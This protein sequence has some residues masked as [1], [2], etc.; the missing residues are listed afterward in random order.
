[1]NHRLLTRILVVVL[2]SSLV[3]GC[4]WI[5]DFVILNTSSGDLAI[6]YVVNGKMC[7]DD[8]F[9]SIPAT[10]TISEL[11]KEQGAWRKLTLSQYTCDPKT[12][13]VTTT[14]PPHSAL[15][16]ARK[17][18]YTGPE[19]YGNVDFDVLRLELKG[20]EGAVSLTGLKV[21]KSFKRQ[22]DVLYVFS[23]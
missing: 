3:A 19:N 14:L 6:T 15:R 11:K 22:S 18:T 23:Y 10:K 2:A 13:A 17:G 1:M 16:V 4:S 21:L 20:T 5:T 7:P 12:M 8:N 9:I